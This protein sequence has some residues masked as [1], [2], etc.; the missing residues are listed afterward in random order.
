MND[1][2]TGPKIEPCGTPVLI[3]IRDDWKPSMSVYCVQLY[4]R[5]QIIETPDIR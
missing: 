3:C 5:H 1:E 4:H 2:K